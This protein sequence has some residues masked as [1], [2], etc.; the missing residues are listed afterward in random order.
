V[1]CA[2]AGA[3]QI[4]DRLSVGLRGRPVP[5]GTLLGKFDVVSVPDPWAVPLGVV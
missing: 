1:R 3:A 5:T 4:R 2:T